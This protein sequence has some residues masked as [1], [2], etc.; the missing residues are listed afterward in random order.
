MTTREV[1]TPDLRVVPTD[2]LKAHEEHDTQRSA[3]L[4]ESIK[5][6]RYMINPPLVAPMGDG[7][8][9]ILD[10]A[11]RAYC[12]DALG[13]PH[14]LVQ[15][16]SYG[17][18]LVELENWQHI[19]AGWKIDAFLQHLRRLSSIRLSLG[20]IADDANMGEGDADHAI[21]LHEEGDDDADEHDVLAQFYLRDGRLLSVQAHTSTHSLYERNAALREVVAVYQKNAALHR[22]TL[23]DTGEVWSLYPDAIALVVFPRY[24]PQDI[25]AAAKIPAYLPPGISRHIVNGRA[26]RVNYPLE[27]LR[28]TDKDLH[29]KNVT[30]RQ[31]IQQ[32][33][34]SRQI[35]YYAEGTYQFDE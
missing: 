28:E 3:P 1:P 22:T 6:A 19:V 31:W 33:L 18:G 17:S 8:Y 7:N 16:A 24:T 26:I 12:F 29:E 5:N 34:A 2:S 35:R 25:I 15:V 4:I 14:I 10:G 30:L 20:D 27:Y 13:Y 11:N 32:K 21:T 9:V 23:T